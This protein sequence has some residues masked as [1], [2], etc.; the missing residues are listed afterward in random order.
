MHTV[1]P[2]QMDIFWLEEAVWVATARIDLPNYD[3]AFEPFFV[4]RRPYH[5][6]EAIT[7]IGRFGVT[8]DYAELYQQ[9][10]AQGVCLIHTPEQYFLATELTHWSSRASSARSGSASPA[11]ATAAMR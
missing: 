5:R 11:P 8:A 2:E 4:C 7:A 1:S 6:P 3:F 9:L 10:A